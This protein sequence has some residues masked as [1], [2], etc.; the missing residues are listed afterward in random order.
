MERHAVVAIPEGLHAR[1]AAQFARLAAAQPVPVRISTGDGPPVD[2]ASILGIMTLG[3]DAGTTVTL[4]VDVPDG[5]AQTEADTARATL[6]TLE[7]F[8]TAPGR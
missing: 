5:A 7:E 6:D 3:A 4:A 8:L 1:P 2:A